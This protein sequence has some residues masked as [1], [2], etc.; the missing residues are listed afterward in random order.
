MPSLSYARHCAE[1]AAQTELLRAC[2]VGADLAAPVPTCPGWNLGQLLWHLGGAHRWAETIVRTRAAGPVSEE[3]VNEVSGA[4]GQ[5]LAALDAWLAEGAGQLAD[6]LRA[7]GPDARVWTVAPGGTPAFWARRMVHETVIHR[8]DA[9]F[10]V[11]AAGSRGA[12]TVSGAAGAPG[13]AT[14]TGAP[15]VSGGRAPGFGVDRDV[16]VDALDEWMDFACLPQVFATTPGLRGVMSGGRTLHFHATDAAPETA[17]DWLIGLGGD[18]L[19]WSR[20][21]APATVA[22]RAPLAE[23]LLLLYGRRSTHDAGT[24]DGNGRDGDSHN[25]SG[26]GGSSS[27]RNAIEITGEVP[28]LD[29]WLDG[30]SFWLKE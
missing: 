12:C 8:A 1:I 10:T 23:L 13:P 3:L 9:L 6:T 2:V 24:G 7:A 30:V 11:A 28:L 16:A 29:A 26:S 14:A 5:D 18:T 22:V 19:T 4:A 20:T 25:G 17:P 15:A 21:P 27:R